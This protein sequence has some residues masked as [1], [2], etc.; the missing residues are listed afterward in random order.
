MEFR[1]DAAGSVVD[2]LRVDHA[3]GQV[4]AFDGARV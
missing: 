2:F 1:G 3:V 4:V